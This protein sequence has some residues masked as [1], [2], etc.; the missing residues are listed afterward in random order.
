MLV[1]FELFCGF[2]HALVLQV[3]NSYAVDVCGCHCRE[4]AMMLTP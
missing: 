1:V 3:A 2:V 4:R